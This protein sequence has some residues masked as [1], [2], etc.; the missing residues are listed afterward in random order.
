M[1]NCVAALCDMAPRR[2]TT[3]I[4]PAWARKGANMELCIPVVLF[5]SNTLPA[6]FPLALLVVVGL[7]SSPSL[8]TVLL[9]ATRSNTDSK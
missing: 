9:S 3:T 8:R 2:W 1:S 4:L 7:P 5:L 6:L